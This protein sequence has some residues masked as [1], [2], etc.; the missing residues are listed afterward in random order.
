MAINLLRDIEDNRKLEQ[1]RS[2]N[3][4]WFYRPQLYWH[5]WSTLLPIVSGHDDYA[6][7]TIMIGWTITGRIIIAL[8]DC[9]EHQCRIDALE[10]MKQ[11][12]NG[13][14]DG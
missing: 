13:E 9:G 12:A 8:G 2:D 5:G 11:V 10:Y 3:R 1:A 4:F 6:R 14:F 7:N